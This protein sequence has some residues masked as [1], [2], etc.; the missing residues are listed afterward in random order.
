M[1]GSGRVAESRLVGGGVAAD[2]SGALEA[3]TSGVC[4]Q[5]RPIFVSMNAFQH[6]IEQVLRY[7]VDWEAT[8]AWMQAAGAIIALAVAIELPRRAKA[9]ERRVFRRTVLVYC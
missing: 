6:F 9:G 7:L 2:H 4:G 3:L 5:N 1:S 8:A